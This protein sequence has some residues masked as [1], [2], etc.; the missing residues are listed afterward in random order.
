[1]QQRHAAVGAQPVGAVARLAVLLVQSLTRRHRWGAAAAAGVLSWPHQS[2]DAWI[3]VR[4]NVDSAARLGCH[5]T[6]QHAA[7]ARRHV[8]REVVA[9]RREGALVLRSEEHTSEL[10]SLAYLVC[11]LLL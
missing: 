8:H 10:Q 1:M 9:D 4:D 2:Q 7:V 5:S 6:E 3:V 11:R